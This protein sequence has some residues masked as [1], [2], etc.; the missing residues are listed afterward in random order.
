MKRLLKSEAMN[1]RI[2]S[3]HDFNAR[4]KRLCFRCRFSLSPCLRVSLSAVHRQ[5]IRELLLP[6][7]IGNFRD[8]GMKR[9]SVFIETIIETDRIHAEAKAAQIRQNADRSQ[10]PR[11]AAHLHKIAHGISQRLARVARSDHVIIAAKPCQVEFARRPEPALAKHAIEFIQVQIRHR[12]RVPKRIRNG[13]KSPVPDP[14]FIECAVHRTIRVVEL[15][16][17]VHPTNNNATK[18]RVPRI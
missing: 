11:G 3:V 18:S 1:P 7:S 8:D 13:R 5:H 4:L 15:D 9:F 10:R 17:C 14:A 6:R 12:K 16:K 2:V